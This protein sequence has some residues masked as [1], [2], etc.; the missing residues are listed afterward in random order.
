MKAIVLILEIFAD[1]TA[2]TDTSADESIA[3][4]LPL[5]L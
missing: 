4:V 3:I 5:K 2:S 1:I